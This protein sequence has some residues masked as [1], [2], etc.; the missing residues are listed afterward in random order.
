ML[1]NVMPNAIKVILVVKDL[2]TFVGY[3]LED[4]FRVTTKCPKKKK[5]IG[6]CVKFHLKIYLGIRTTFDLLNNYPGCLSYQCPV[7]KKL[8]IKVRKNYGA[9]NF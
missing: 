6:L 5:K 1:F 2:L 7:S 4:K 3:R 8:K 9:K